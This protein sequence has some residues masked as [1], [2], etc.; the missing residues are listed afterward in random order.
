MRDGY[1]SNALKQVSWWKFTFLIY[2][3]FIPFWCGV[4]HFQTITYHRDSGIGVFIA[5]VT[6]S[7]VHDS[8]DTTLQLV[9]ALCT[10][11]ALKQKCENGT[12]P[13]S[14]DRKVLKWSDV[15]NIHD[16]AISCLSFSYGHLQAINR[17]HLHWK[18]ENIHSKSRSVFRDHLWIVQENH[19]RR[20]RPMQVYQED[21]IKQLIND[22]IQEYE[23]DIRTGNI[24][25]L[26]S[27]SLH[28]SNLYCGA[29]YVLKDEDKWT[30]DTLCKWTPSSRPLEWGKNACPW[31]M[32]VREESFFLFPFSLT[33]HFFLTLS[34]RKYHR[35]K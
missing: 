27:E 25:W 30:W 13:S 11:F 22:I 31:R 7:Q 8:L 28:F 15:F 3:L 35:T 29:K 19:G 17:T 16:L 1:R 21:N 20:D 33:W 5:E 23:D 6:W 26:K 24:C 34:D 10:I 12:F 14:S 4:T 18:W 2:F 32:L 9:G